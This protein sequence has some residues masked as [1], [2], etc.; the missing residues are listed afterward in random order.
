MKDIVEFIAARVRIDM[1]AHSFVSLA[2]GL[3]AFTVFGLGACGPADSEDSDGG[4]V[5]GTLIVSPADVELIVINGATAS[6]TYQVELEEP[7]GSRSDVTDSVS[8]QLETP[9]LGV[10]AG[11]TL[12]VQGSALGESLL[13]A[14]ID[15]AEGEA[16]V[17]VRMTSETVDDSAPSDAADLFAAATEDAAIAPTIVY[18]EAGTLF[19]P[20]LGTFDVHWTTPGSQ[21]VFELRAQSDFADIT[22]YTGGIQETLGRWAELSAATWKTLGSD[23]RGSR[24]DVTLRGLSSAAPSSAGTAA[25]L[26]VGVSAEEIEGGIY[27]WAASFDS[28]TD[29]I[30]RYD[31]GAG[32]NEPE[33]FYTRAESPEGRCVG[34]HAISRSG[35]RMAL[36]MDYPGGSGSILDVGTRD[37]IVELD[38]LYWDFAAFSPDGERLLTVVD[39]TIT[40]RDPESGAELS[41]TTGAGIPTHPDFSPSG[42]QVVYTSA[43]TLGNDWTFTNGRL[44]TRSFNPTTNQFGPEVSLLSEASANVYYPSYSPDGEWIVYSRSTNDAYDDPSAEVFVIRA[45]GSAAP[46]KLEI[47]NIGSGLTNSWVRWAPFTFTVDPSAET[48]EPLFWFTFSSKRAYGVRLSQG[49]PQLWMAPFYPSRASSTENNSAAFRM[50]FQQIT[51]GNHIAQW[52]QEV[53]SID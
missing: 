37:P 41:Q 29:G 45:D 11:S 3:A 46:V 35:E 47:A 1:A 42:L 6:Q 36:T 49:M 32:N 24:V 21:D 10:F 18:P 28:G 27:Y 12:N 13:W 20:N 44:V 5:S 34:C 38:T 48:D 8:W 52:T 26:S 7:D 15:G 23:A 22:I 19:P 9:E 43:P 17:T 31:M 40:V 50:P 16:Q 14:R 53:I 2:F 25:P 4:S 30:Y 39:G 33:A 51:T